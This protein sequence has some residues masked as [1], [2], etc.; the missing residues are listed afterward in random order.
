MADPADTAMMQESC[1]C[2]L[3][4]AHIGIP[5]AN[6]RLS[7]YLP[8][9]MHGAMNDLSCYTVLFTK[10]GAREPEHAI[11]ANLLSPHKEI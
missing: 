10:R 3:V 2:F 4:G 9:C 7:K 11:L 5:Y 1:G 6:P 8:T